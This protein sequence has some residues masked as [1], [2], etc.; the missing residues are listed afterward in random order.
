MT[1]SV[2][3]WS[4]DLVTSRALSATERNERGHTAAPV[5]FFAS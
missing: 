4:T 2:L 1:A 5:L 3:F